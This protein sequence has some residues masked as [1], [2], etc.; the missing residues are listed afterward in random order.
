MYMKKNDFFRR[1]FAMLMV[2]MLT[3]NIGTAASAESYSASVMRLLNYE[4]DV[5]IL[6]ADGNARFLME[7]V[8]F[9]SG[10]SLSTGAKAMASVSL[11]ATKILTLDSMTQ[12]TF[13]KANNHMTLTLSSGRLLLDVQAKLDENETFDIQTSTMTVGIRGTTI[14]LSSFDGSEEEINKALLESN[15]SFRELLNRTLPEG[16]SGDF[17]QLVVLEGAA[18]ATYQ[19]TNRQARSVEVHAGEKI[20]VVDDRREEPAVTQAMNHDLGSD[21]VEFIKNDPV[22]SENGGVPPED[23]DALPPEGIEP[24]EIEFEL[25]GDVP[26]FPEEQNG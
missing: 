17:S 5:Y 1:C 21:M 10:E 13:V 15:A 16:Y 23:P 4:G 22:L 6:D 7:N 3:L 26:Y 9:N 14:L 11:D 8:R 18:V 24:V 2:F 20:T 19:D 12:V 25:A